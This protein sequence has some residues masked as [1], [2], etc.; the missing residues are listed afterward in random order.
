MFAASNMDTDD[1]P[2]FKD[3]IMKNDFYNGNSGGMYEEV[4]HDY[5]SSIH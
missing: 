2:Y 4:D 1:S 3:D 5:E